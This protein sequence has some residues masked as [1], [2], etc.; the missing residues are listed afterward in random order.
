M[1]IERMKVAESPPLLRNGI[2]I[3]R[4]LVIAISLLFLAILLAVGLLVGL[5]VK[6]NNERVI[7]LPPTEMTSNNSI[8]KDMQKGVL[9]TA[10]NIDY[11]SIWSWSMDS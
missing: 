8:Q 7:V 6:H 2:Y 5:L 3:S 9:S 4:Y 10:S 1:A 11:R